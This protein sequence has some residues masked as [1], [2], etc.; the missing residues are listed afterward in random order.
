VGM[1]GNVNPGEVPYEVLFKLGLITGPVL[2]LF[3]IIPW[4]ASTQFR[5]SRES[6]AEIKKAL[7]GKKPGM[8][9]K[10]LAS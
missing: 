1:P 3:F 4:F 2:G 6:H 7:E 10:D 9:G 8:T 5:L